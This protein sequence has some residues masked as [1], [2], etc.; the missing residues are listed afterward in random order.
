MAYW[1]YR[2]VR[3][4]SRGENTLAIHEAHYNDHGHVW[5]I[6]MEPEAVETEGGQRG[7]QRVYTQ[8]AEA[9][10]KPILDYEE[11]GKSKSKCKRCLAE[12][13]ECCA[14]IGRVVQ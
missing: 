3:R 1:N 13:V 8:M 2:I 6:S 10:S 11:I 14:A 12:A 9:F 7:L 4:K 5:A